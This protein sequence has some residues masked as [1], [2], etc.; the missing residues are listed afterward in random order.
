M[1]EDFQLLDN[2]PIHNSTIKRDYLKIYHQQGAQFN[3]SDQN[4]QFN[5][6]GNNNYHQIGNGYLDFD[7]KVRRK[8][9]NK[10][11][12]DDPIRLVK[13]AFAFCF[14]E[15]R[16]STTIGRDIEYNEFSGQVSTIM[17]VISSKDGDPL[18]QFDNI[19]EKDLTPR[20]RLANVPIPI[21]DTTLR[22]MLINNRTDVSKGKIKG[23]LYL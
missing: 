19:N 2:Q 17:K 22:K 4:I 21:R 8:D 23:Y 20:E 12:N 9:N 6:G 16:L 5:F 18:S 1:I 13:N 10:F 11:A 14:K 7:I 15:A 3:Q